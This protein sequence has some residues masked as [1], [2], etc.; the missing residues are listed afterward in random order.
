MTGDKNNSIWQEKGA[1]L[2][3]LLNNLIFM[4]YTFFGTNIITNKLIRC[5][6]KYLQN[7]LPISLELFLIFRKKLV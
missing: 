4:F 5:R 1:I 6:H 2:I 3:R 7:I